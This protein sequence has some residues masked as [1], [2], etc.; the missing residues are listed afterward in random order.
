[1]DERNRLR[2]ARTA[3]YMRGVQHRAS[4]FAL[5][6]A[7]LEQRRHETLV[8]A[9]RTDVDATFAHWS[10][11]LRRQALDQD[12]IRRFSDNSAAQE[13]IL[14][15]ALKDL[16]DA[17][18]QR[19]AAARAESEAQVRL[20]QASSALEALRKR[21]RRKTDELALRALEDRI[22]YQSGALK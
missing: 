18:Q 9:R 4:S 3:Q 22:S 14:E 12:R 2:A 1:M 7:A 16:N 21:R 8:E 13:R 10:E 11:H 5:T 15:A 19:Q 20:R 17:A 6:E